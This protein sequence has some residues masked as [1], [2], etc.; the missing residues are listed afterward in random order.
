MPDTT[1]PVPETA[2][3]PLDTPSSWR[4][5]LIAAAQFLTRLPLGDWIAVRDTSLSRALRA[6]P[7]VGALI[8]CAGAAVYGLAAVFGA[9]P[10]AAALLTIGAVA[11]LTG[12]L[13]EDGLADC[14]D[15]FGG[16]RDRE[17]KLAIM[18]D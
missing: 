7:L 8:G 14:A 10:L 1:P 13:H 11:W 3:E 5:D 9:P 15:G 6:F 16:G 17:A 18:H 4:D 2:T 12:G